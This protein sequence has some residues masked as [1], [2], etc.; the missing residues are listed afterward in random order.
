[1]LDPRIHNPKMF[2]QLA[3]ALK[4]EIS[5]IQLQGIEISEI[6]L[7]GIEISEIQLQGINLKV[8]K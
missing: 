8:R 7:Q 2:C 6:Q 1:M 5:E 4:L 3:F